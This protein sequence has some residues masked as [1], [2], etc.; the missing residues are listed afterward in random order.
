M[1]KGLMITLTLLTLTFICACNE[2]LPLDNNESQ[3][4]SNNSELILNPKSNSIWSN[5]VIYQIWVRSFYDSD[6]DGN[7]D[8]L[9]I[10]EKLDYIRSL[11]VDAIWLSPI[12]ASPSYHGYDVEDFY[13][14]NPQYG[15]LDDLKNL[16][17]KSHSYG[18]KVILDI[19][20]NHVS[21]HHPWFQKALNNDKKYS[22]YFVWSNK[23]PSNAGTAWGNDID[24]YKVWHKKNSRPDYYYGVFGW[25]QPDLNFKN[26]DVLN[27]IL[28]V[29]NYWVDIGIDGIRFD[30]VRYL[31]EDDSVS[32][33][34]DTKSNLNLWSK[35]RHS[36][37]SNNQ[38]IL[39]IGEAYTNLDNASKYYLDGSGFD[40]VFDFEFRH[41]VESI[42]SDYASL[43]SSKRVSRSIHVNAIKDSLWNIF[44]KRI[45][46]NIPHD[47][48]NVFLNNHDLDRFSTSVEMHPLKQKIA[49]SIMLSMPVSN[50]IYYGEEIGLGQ[51][52][53]GFDLYRRAPM[54]WS[55][56]I[57]SGFSNS[58]YLWVDNSDWFYWD[59]SFLPWWKSYTSNNRQIDTINVNSQTL[60]DESLL[61]H[62][63][64]LIA[65]K[66]NNETFNSP[67]SIKRI[68]TTS[69][70]F[71][72]KYTKGDEVLFLVLNL[73]H[74]REEV[75][76][77]GAISRNSFTNL[78]NRRL[79]TIDKNIKLDKGEFMV[80]K[81]TSS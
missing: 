40:M 17:N 29:L 46:T 45:S 26:P 58:E 10:I 54:Q 32:G 65:L 71:C 51:Y 12:F 35:I 31:I 48:F 81:R 61:N 73:S 9:G 5:K 50:T 15:T 56:D 47:Y 13:K 57:N 4:S 78:L 28:K 20:I 76:D 22:D 44:D 68:D 39:L 19:P 75:L 23:P 38:N 33:R 67:E 34:S 14:I 25:T 16:L 66:R 52:R 36:L 77:S 18:I 74:D 80:L 70:I 41:Q 60:K 64:S 6:N 49:A 11:G 2:N 42:L 79:I 8:I 37:K 21:E 24:P 3:A 55:M 72:L 43:Y 1:P 53:N 7:G 69:N 62:Y 59:T 63:K 27:D 30:A